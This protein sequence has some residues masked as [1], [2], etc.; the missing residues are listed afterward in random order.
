M[1]KVEQPVIGIVNDEPAVLESLRFLLEVAGHA[2]ET[3]TSA[4]DLLEAETQE[5][6]CV[7]LD[8]HMPH[9]TGLELAERLRAEGWGIPIILIASSPSPTTLLRAAKSGIDRVLKK[10][11]DYEDLHNFADATRSSGSSPYPPDA[12][13]SHPLIRGLP[14]FLRTGNTSAGAT[15]ESETDFSGW[16]KYPRNIEIFLCSQFPEAQ[17][18]RTNEVEVTSD[19]ETALPKAAP[20][21]NIMPK[22][23]GLMAAASDDD[24]K[25]EPVIG[26]KEASPLTGRDGLTDSGSTITP[27]T[28]AE[29]RLAR[30]GQPALSEKDEAARNAAI[31][32]LIAERAY[33]LWENQGR[34]HGYDLT[35]WLEA[36]Q[37]IKGCL[38][39]GSVPHGG[40][41]GED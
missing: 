7:I 4:A 36:E 22:Q 5:L 10:P 34:P 29:G 13:N 6:T 2:V 1:T 11:A 30:N 25:P 16:Y 21:P 17:P 38:E 19:K 9:I 26:S 27:V 32:Q 31:H 3:F 8:H 12:D 37:E 14:I 28:D 18:Y 33:E 15:I 23:S 40:E 20:Q 24:T 35:D 41:S 39:Y